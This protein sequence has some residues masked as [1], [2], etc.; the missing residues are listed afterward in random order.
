MIVRLRNPNRDL[1]LTG[2]R[3]VDELMVELECNR[4]ATLVIVNGTLV[5]GNTRLADDDVIEVR[6]VISGG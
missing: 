6:S 1:E 5:P 2:P 3:S 4:E